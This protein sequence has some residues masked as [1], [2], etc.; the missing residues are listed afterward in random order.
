MKNKILAATILMLPLGLFLFF[1]WQPVP[2]KKPVAPLNTNSNWQAAAIASAL[3]G[4]N[5]NTVAIIV[6]NFASVRAVAGNLSSATTTVAIAKSAPFAPLQF[7]NFAPAIVLENVRRA[8]R[9]YG[10]LF[11]GNPVGN[12]SEITAALAGNNPKGI[13]FINAEAGMRVSG[14]GELVDS[15]GTPFFFHQLSGT[16]MEIHSAGPDR[17][18]WTSDDLVNR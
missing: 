3:A 7:T 15:W 13:N 1:W 6:S 11:G 16:E 17:I 5:S 9:Q 8:V 2:G 4:Q 12:N 10:D 14:N 18:M